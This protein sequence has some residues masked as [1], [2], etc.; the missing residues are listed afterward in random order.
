MKVWRYKPE[1]RDAYLENNLDILIELIKNLEPGE[2]VKINCIEIN[3]E[4]WDSLPKEIK[5]F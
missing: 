4:T 5:G 2:V 1:G 3:E